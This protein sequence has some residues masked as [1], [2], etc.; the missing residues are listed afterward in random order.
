MQNLDYVISADGTI[1]YLKDLGYVISNSSPSGNPADATTYYF[2]IQSYETTANQAYNVVPQNGTLR[3]IDVIV[4]VGGT[5]GTNEPSTLKFRLNNTTD[6][7]V[8]VIQEDAIIQ[9]YSFV[10]TANDVPINLVAGDTFEFKW[11]TPTWVTNPT[12]VRIYYNIYISS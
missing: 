11:L 2:G 10:P 1:H 12:G 9:R 5:L 4:F 8:A 3:R 7:D 6:Y